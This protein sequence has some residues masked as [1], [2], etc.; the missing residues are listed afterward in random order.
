MF[1]NASGERAQS[2]KKNLNALLEAA[3]LKTDVFGQVRSAYSFWH[4][5]A[6]R[7]PRKGTDVYTLAINMRTSVRMIELYYSDV[8]PNDLPGMSGLELLR[9]LNARGDAPASIM[10]TG[11]SDVQTAVDAMKAGALDFIEKPIGRDMLLSIVGRAL[12]EAKDTERR[13]ARQ[14]A[15]VEHVAGLTSRQHQ[16]MDLVLAGHP[17]KNIAADLG[18]SQRT[19]ENHRAAIMK[20]TG[21]RSLPELARLAVAAAAVPPLPH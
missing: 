8:V 14:H 15:A 5:Y 2:Y 20:K 1:V 21:A 16:I 9:Q 19:V 7:Q 13:A 3:K 10:I 18:I 11:G 17:S 6:T 12:G 4:T